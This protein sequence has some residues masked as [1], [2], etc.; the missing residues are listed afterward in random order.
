[1]L[2]GVAI[3]RLEAGYRIYITR[4]GKDELVL[5]A[6]GDKSSQ[7]RDIKEAQAAVERLK[8]KAKPSKTDR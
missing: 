1:M 8:G 7:S 2:M 6:G 5:L 3:A 4:R